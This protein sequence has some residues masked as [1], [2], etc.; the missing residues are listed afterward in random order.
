[1][2]VGPDGRLYI[3]TNLGAAGAGSASANPP[4][5]L[6]EHWRELVPERA[7]AALSHFVVLDGRPAPAAARRSDRAVGELAVHDLATGERGSRMCRCP[8]PGTVGPSTRPAGG[9]EAWFVYTDTVTP[10]RRL[11]LR[12]PH[13]RPPCGPGRPGWN[14]A[15][16]EA[17]PVICPSRRR[18]A[19]AGDRAR[20]RTPAGRGRR[21]STA[22]AVSASAD[23]DLLEL[24]PGLGGGRRCLRDRA[25]ARRWR[26]KATQWHRAGC[27]T[28][29]R[30]CST[31]SSPPPRG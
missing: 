20:P 30:T 11:P 9:H 29:S 8:A 31:T 3:V 4:R 16:I 21:S 17:Q 24:R 14:R 6:P 23:A 15:A 2:H 18:H 25:P 13:R 12:R 7:E 5:P 19:G 27:W 22:T 1:M 28:A 10:D 26:S